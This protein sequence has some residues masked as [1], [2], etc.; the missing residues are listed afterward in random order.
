MGPSVEAG[1]RASEMSF[2]T[3]VILPRETASDIINFTYQSFPITH[4]EFQRHMN[5]LNN[6]FSL[7]FISKL[8]P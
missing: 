6:V 8:N 2:T 1:E 3:H 7:M 4:L 5:K